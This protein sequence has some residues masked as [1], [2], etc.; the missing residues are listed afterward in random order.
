MNFKER[1]NNVDMAE[2]LPFFYKAGIFIFGGSFLANGYN[3]YRTWSIINWGARISSILTGMLF[4]L[5][6]ML[7]FYYSYKQLDNQP[8]LNHNQLLDDLE[9]ELKR[10]DNLEELNNKKDVSKEDIRKANKEMWG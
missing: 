6:L 9:A 3:L 7:L 1:L 4:S 10:V 5:M 2:F 8:Q